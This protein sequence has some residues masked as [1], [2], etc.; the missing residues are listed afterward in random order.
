MG[1]SVGRKSFSVY[2]LKKVE[3]TFV[4]YGFLIK[5][6]VSFVDVPHCAAHGLLFGTGMSTW[7]IGFT[8]PKPPVPLGREIDRDNVRSLELINIKNYLFYLL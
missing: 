5:D 8:I 7:Y 3:D 4:P 2:I 6:V 1:S